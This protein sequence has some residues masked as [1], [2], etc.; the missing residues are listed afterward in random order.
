MR[1]F[2]VAFRPMLTRRFATLAT[3]AA[4][5]LC[6]LSASFAN[7]SAPFAALA[8]RSN[9]PQVIDI[10]TGITTLPEGG[11]VIDKETGVSFTAGH[12][13]YLDG[14]FI[15]A[16]GVQMEGAFGQLSADVVR[17]DIAADILLATG[18]LILRREGLEV[19]AKELRYYADN[20]VAV[21]EGGVTGNQPNF[22]AERVLLDVRSGDVLLD[23]H[24]SFA[25]DLF[26]MRSPAEGGLLE[27]R[28]VELEDYVT[29]SAASEVS[30]S[31]LER[32]RAY[33]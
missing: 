9:G 32:F 21:F 19:M 23:G 28:L 16:T 14:A 33:L 2:D 11:S 17:I 3:V 25:G 4:V 12:I 31:L 27:L 30:P 6:L 24:Y 5:V 1:K 8:V 10:T 18:N 26:T 22:T 15:E 13:A 7:D 29:Y 20:E